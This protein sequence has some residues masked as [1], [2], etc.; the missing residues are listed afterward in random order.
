MVFSTVIQLSLLMWIGV[1]SSPVKAT[2][3]KFEKKLN[4][5]SFHDL[6]SK[7]FSQKFSTYS[8]AGYMMI[9]ID[10]YPQGQNLLYSMIWRKNTDSRAWAEHRNLTSSQ[11]NTK[12]QQYKDRGFRPID[13]AAYTNGNRTLFAGIWVENIENIKWSS[14]RN[15]SRSDYE[16]LFNSK[17]RAGFRL[18]DMEVYQTTTG[19]KY[20]AI[21]YKSDDRSWSHS[22]NLTRDQYQAEVGDKVSEGFIMIDFESW[23]T[24]KGKRYAAIWERKSGY[25]QIIRTNRS[26]LAFINLWNQY[27]DEGFRLVDFEHNGDRY[28]GIWLENA[29]RYRHPQKSSFDRLVE[30]YRSDNNLPS[31]SVTMI[32]NDNIIYRRGFGFADLNTGKKA[33]SETIY[34]AASVSKV[35]GATLAAKLE[36]NQKLSDGRIFQLDLSDQTEEYLGDIG[37]PSQHT[38]TIEQLFSH[39]ACIAH[40]STTPAIANQTNHYSQ[41]IEAAKSIWKTGLVQKCKIGTT[42]SYSTP[43]FTL[44]AAALE[45]AT[46]RTITQLLNDELFTPHNLKMRVHFA[47]STPQT[48]YNRAIPYNSRNSPVS[49]ADNSWKAIGGGIETSSYQLTNFG[50]QILKGKIVSPYVRDNRLWNRI[51]P[52]QRSGLGWSVI[53]TESRR[54]AE[55]SGSWTGARSFIRVY[56]DDNLVISIMSNR[57]DHSI[58]D[59]RVLTANLADTIFN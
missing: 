50:W 26:Q 17:N 46:G 34:P 8:K 19:L 39:L 55:H 53:T 45:A 43:S 57:R 10:A 3:V 40:Y 21:W 47:T 11:Y 18:V 1:T 41:A 23:P 36:A 31:I 33:H 37:L 24:T 32:H 59:V 38:H 12:W 14:H 27:K 44:A 15:L 30:K 49:Y 22:H 9:D 28:S 51:N 35:I 16:K 6:T 2:I 4:W 52:S 29:V 54:V 7:D 13:I 58:D 5:A 20:S 42:R 56:R 48:D 25:A